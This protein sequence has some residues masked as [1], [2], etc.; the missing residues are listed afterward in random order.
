MTKRI[1]GYYYVPKARRE[2]VNSILAEA[3]F[4]DDFFS[5]PVIRGGGHTITH[6]GASCS[7]PDYLQGTLTDALKGTGAVS[8]SVTGKRT[9]AGFRAA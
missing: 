9:R 8:A 6:Y 3:G 7:L 5:V 1:S 2:A 4:G